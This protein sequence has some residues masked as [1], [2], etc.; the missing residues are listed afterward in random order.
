[1]Y[2]P[3]LCPVQRLYDAIL[4][5]DERTAAQSAALLARAFHDDDTPPTP[6]MIAPPSGFLGLAA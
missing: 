5:G 6:A 2:D 4:R 1:M 3:H